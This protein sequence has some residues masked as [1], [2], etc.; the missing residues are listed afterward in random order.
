MKFLSMENYVLFRDYGMKGAIPDGIDGKPSCCGNS[1]RNAAFLETLAT[2]GMRLREAGS[3]LVDD[4]PALPRDPKVLVVP[5]VLP[6]RTT[7]GEKG[8]T[9]KLPTR[10]LREIRHYIKIERANA[11]ARAQQRGLY[12]SF[13]GI[14]VHNIERDLARIEGG[15]KVRSIHLSRLSP[16]QRRRLLLVAE[17]V[18]EPRALWLTETG[19][20]MSLSAWES[21]F[22]RGTKRCQSLKIDIVAT[23]HTMRHTFAVHM[24]SS[25]D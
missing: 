14:R 5:L 11:I 21:V 6:A 24:L 1:G 20:P 18:V 19:M 7:K 16:E 15:G 4:L 25:A 9:V 8:R 2:T 10:I 3:L 13:A 12:D 23:P 22:E 17:Q